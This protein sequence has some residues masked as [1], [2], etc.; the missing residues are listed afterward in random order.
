MAS[1][2]AT[3]DVIA[4]ISAAVSRLANKEV[5]KFSKPL[6][7]QSTVL[8]PKEVLE[9]R[10]LAHKHEKHLKQIGAVSKQGNK[11]KLKKAQSDY[12]ASYSAR[13]CAVVRVL[14][15]KRLHASADEV[16]KL[17]Q[18]LDMTP[19]AEPVNARIVEKPKGGWRVVVVI[20]LLRTAQQLIVRDM[21]YALD[22][23]SEFDFARKGAGGEKAFIGSICNDIVD[24]R[25]WVCTVDVKNFFPS[26]RAKHFDWLPIPK[27][28]L[29]NV[30]FLPKCAKIRVH[31]PKE[32]IT[33]HSADNLSTELPKKSSII[34]LLR[35][36]LPTGAV[37]SPLL[38]RSLLGRELHILGEKW[39]VGKSSIMD[40]V[41]MR[42]W[43][44][45]D[46][47][48][49]FDALKMQ[50]LLLP[51][52]PL[53]LHAKAPVYAPT[54]G[55]T[56]LGYRLLPGEGYDDNPVHVKPGG[57]RIEKHKR[58][59][60]AKLTAAA[61]KNLDLFEIG[62]EY[63]GQWYESQQ[64]WTKVPGYSWQVSWSATQGY[65]Q[66]FKSGIPMGQNAPMLIS[67]ANKAP[68]SD[69]SD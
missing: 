33:T 59:L 62:E 19:L 67:S 46:A 58:K 27:D 42:A 61:A 44:Q 45:T 17:A 20:G 12:F 10:H 31:Y 37:H 11:Y 53:E 39:D 14:R 32:N 26:L 5:V 2:L 29:R 43:S 9:L 63:W 68:P 6:S 23:D 18:C 52:G 4:S 28:I 34:R 40:D 50:L 3:Q 69:N 65:I 24:G 8:G 1:S 60:F 57:R 66:D 7:S 38:A 15:R 22:I 35:Q 64:A 47:V 55:A 13:I 36:G 54:K 48:S 41:S 25:N 56:V 21:L 49:A 16:H 51:A 30:V